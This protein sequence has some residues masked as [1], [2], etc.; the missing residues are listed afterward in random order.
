MENHH[1][2]KTFELKQETK[3]G[4]IWF[5]SY[6]NS[7]ISARV[8]WSKS[9]VTTMVRGA[10]PK[11]S[12]RPHHCLNEWFFCLEHI[13]DYTLGL[14]TY[15]KKVSFSGLV[16]LPFAAPWL[17]WDK[18]SVSSSFLWRVVCIFVD[19]FDSF[20]WHFATSLFWGLIS[21]RIYIWN[22]K[23][24]LWGG[25]SCETAERYISVLQADKHVSIVLK[26]KKKNSWP[27]PLV[28]LVGNFCLFLCWSHILDVLYSKNI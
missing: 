27:M 4:F 3:Q 22:K 19:Y 26:K 10:K 17:H 8:F 23:I 6:K 15:L 11:R 14:R 5:S 7:F 28:I 13:V 9:L 21:W 12:C 18:T 20:L 2:G 16:E 25:N 24:D 1:E